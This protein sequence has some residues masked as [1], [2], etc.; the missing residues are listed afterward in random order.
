MN[1][2]WS[3]NIAFVAWPHFVHQKQYSITCLCDSGW[4]NIDT[5]VALAYC[6]CAMVGLMLANECWKTSGPTSQILDGPWE[7]FCWSVIKR[8]R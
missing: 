6:H 5:I 4:A 3:V 1:Q 2:C 7:V 8:W